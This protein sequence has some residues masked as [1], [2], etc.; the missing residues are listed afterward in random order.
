MTR[1]VRGRPVRLGAALHR[2]PARAGEG[3]VTRPAGEAGNA[4]VEFLAVALV[5]LVPLV[6]LVLVIGRVE[7][8]SFAVEGAAREAARVAA[9]ADTPADAQRR[10]IAVVGIALRDQGFDDDPAD[11]LRLTCSSTPCLA[12]G[13]TVD[14]RVEVDVELPFVPSFVRSVVPLEIPVTAERVAAVDAY[15]GAS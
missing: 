5:L 11:A 15:R 12:P 1:A 13:S 10:A 3:V 7:A 14:A 9:G 8:A 4:Q 6:Y 2:P